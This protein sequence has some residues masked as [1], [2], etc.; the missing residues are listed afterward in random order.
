M[1]QQT[2][3]EVIGMVQVGKTAFQVV[4]FAVGD[5]TAAHGIRNSLGLLGPRGAAYL[6]VDHGPDFRL[7]VLRMTG[8]GASTSR[9][10]PELTRAHLAAFGVEA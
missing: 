4:R 9:A 2:G 1:T 6:V 7:G 3:A 10:L 8:A 5:K